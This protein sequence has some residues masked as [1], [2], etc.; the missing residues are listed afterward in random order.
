MASDSEDIL[1][2]ISFRN[3][4]TFVCKLSTGIF[5][6]PCEHKQDNCSTITLDFDSSIYHPTYDTT[7]SVG[8]QYH[9]LVCIP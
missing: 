7:C 4:R 8:R 2:L 1:E 6:D 9:E 3:L 5:S